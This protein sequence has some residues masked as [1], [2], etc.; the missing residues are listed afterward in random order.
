M[1]TSTNQ[2]HFVASTARAQ[3]GCAL[4]HKETGAFIC[5]PNPA[6]HPE[7]ANV[8]QLFHLSAQGNAETTKKIRHY[9]VLIDGARVYE[10]R[11]ATP[12]HRISIETN[13][14]APSE[15]GQHTISVYIDGAGTAKVSNVG[16]HPSPNI[17]FCDPFE[18]MDLR[19]CVQTRVRGPLVW[20][21]PPESAIQDS[22]RSPASQS[23]GLGGLFSGYLDLFSHN[24]KSLETDV[25][26]AA[27]VDSEGSLFVASH[28]FGDIDVRKYD[29]NGSLLADTIVR[30][31][32]PGFLSISG[33]VEDNAGNA[34]VAGNTTSVFQTTPQALAPVVDVPPQLHGFVM[35]I[36]MSR[37]GAVPSYLTYP[38]GLRNQINALLGDRDG[39]IYF[40]GVTSS[41]EF[42]HQTTLNLSS[43]ATA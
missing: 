8:P 34:W 14:K 25:A 21:L 43:S 7:D 32:R 2:H 18:R 36:D 20:S 9:V 4:A 41:N 35:H 30:A 42:P 16:F 27:T 17:G 5:F 26:D 23:S 22:T 12:L 37:S 3:T 6:D 15:G 11:L 24:L 28:S 19:N 1:L 39:N 10:V 33:I 40:A 38:F 29:R 31:T 13:V